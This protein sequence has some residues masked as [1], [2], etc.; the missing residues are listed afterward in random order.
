MTKT[1]EGKTFSRGEIALYSFVLDKEA[2]K[3]LLEPG[4]LIDIT[5][6]N[7]ALARLS[8]DV[9]A[10]LNTT[11]RDKDT[12]FPERII[13][14]YRA[15]K[16]EPVEDV[17]SNLERTLQQLG[18]SIHLQFPYKPEAAYVPIRSLYPKSHRDRLR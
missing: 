8:D 18:E 12:R 6:M 2:A 7:E 17:H 13:L 9:K 15:R 16:D 5:S 1:P 10:Y 11:Q 14:V 3:K 4:R